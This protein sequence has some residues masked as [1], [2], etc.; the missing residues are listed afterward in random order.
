M[1]KL[2]CAGCEENVAGIDGDAAAEIVGA[3][4]SRAADRPAAEGSYCS[5]W[6]C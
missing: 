5:V 4:A 6:G 1:N 2:P 3:Y